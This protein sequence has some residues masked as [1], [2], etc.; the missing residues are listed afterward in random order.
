MTGALILK[1]GEEVGEVSFDPYEYEYGG[2]NRLV[3]DILQQAKI[4]TGPDTAAPE[5]GDGLAAETQ[6]K[7][8]GDPLRYRLEKEFAI[9]DHELAVREPDT[10]EKL[11]QDTMSTLQKLHEKG[12]DVTEDVVDFV[13]KAAA[14]RRYID[15]ESEAP[16]GA[17]VQQ[18]PN[19]GLY[20]EPGGGGGG[21]G[22]G[23]TESD[24]ATASEAQ[25]AAN[26]V[27]NQL[28]YGETDDQEVQD[29]LGKIVETAEA[30][31]IEVEP[32][33]GDE[34]GIAAAQDLQKATNRLVNQLKHG[35]PSEDE[36]RDI[37]SEMGELAAGM[38]QGGG[39]DTPYTSVDELPEPDGPYASWDEVPEGD[40]PDYVQEVM[41]DVE[42]QRSFK[43]GDHPTEWER[44]EPDELDEYVSEMQETEW[45]GEGLESFEAAF[46]GDD[47]TYNE[48]TDDDGA[49]SA[50]RLEEVHDPAV[51]EMLN[52][53]AAS[54]EPIGVILMGPPGA[55]KGWWEENYAD[56][57]GREF[58]RINSDDAKHHI[59]EYEGSNAAEVHE[60]SSHIAKKELAPEAIERGH[61][62]VFDNVAS[63]STHELKE[64][65]E[66]AGH[67][68]RAVF[69]DV[70]PEKSAHNVVSR[71]EDEGRFTPL[72]YTV[73]ARED[74]LGTFEEATDDMD[75]E[76][77]AYYNNDVE[78]GE[79]P[80]A[81]EEGS[82]LF[83]LLQKL[84]AKGRL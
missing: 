66:E 22:D 4:A 44:P 74:S 18:G 12:V 35:S 34:P 26:R 45:W 7:L 13:T 31:G 77:V 48:H 32:G 39:S 28:Q 19:G 21:G 53:D 3:K 76:K 36:L 51:E 71:Y 60:E 59:P 82:A 64:A 78:W 65:M 61:N 17:K 14:E 81:E 8:E 62:I 57:F 72:D 54:D 27:V 2:E 46:H 29:A 63:S 15:D 52:E 80:E 6:V 43:T 23:S 58:T 50:E 40:R 68:M 55:G 83:K 47:N 16:E 38:L 10:D 79:P 49:W 25:T 30:A 70:P 1:D 69:V 5:E 9:T 42:G 67:D 37:L 41:D 33:G 73:G 84:A 56:K 20:Y 75:P 24:I 11:A